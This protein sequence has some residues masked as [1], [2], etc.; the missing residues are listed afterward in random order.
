M[1]WCGLS[2]VLMHRLTFNFGNALSVAGFSM[3]IGSFMLLKHSPR[4]LGFEHQEMCCRYPD[5]SHRSLLCTVCCM[6]FTHCCVC[7][8][9]QHVLDMRAQ[10]FHV[11]GCQKNVVPLL[12]VAWT[13]TLVNIL[14][15][16]QMETQKSDHK[17]YNL[18]CS[19]Y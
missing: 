13:R 11:E 16:I 4:A 2:S 17:F 19:L 9:T 3:S 10:C 5:I 14:G 1:K 8:L 18:P 7:H 12:G 6:C 15:H